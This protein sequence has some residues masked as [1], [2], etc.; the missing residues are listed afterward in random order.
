MLTQ[1]LA[2]TCGVAI[3][4]SWHHYCYA[5]WEYDTCPTPSLDQSLHE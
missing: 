2:A 4:T 5:R 1:F 3:A